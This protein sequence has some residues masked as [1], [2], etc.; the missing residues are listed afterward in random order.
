[1]ARDKLRERIR[2]KVP[3][4]SR[5]RAIDKFTAWEYWYHQGL[6][7][8][9]SFKIT[10]MAEVLAIVAFVKYVVL[11]WDRAMTISM[12]VL[13]IVAF[14]WLLFRTWAYWRLGRFWHNNGG[15]QS[16][17][18]WNV[19]KVPPGRTEVINFHDQALMTAMYLR[20]DKDGLTD[21][22]KDLEERYR[23]DVT[24]EVKYHGY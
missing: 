24:G 22:I 10:T 7:I 15:Y 12:I 21:A 3:K 16:K 13:A 5:K 4:L 1:L 9:Q 2:G 17:S 14:I 23:D 11:G 19:G 20:M 18:K 6:A 8:V